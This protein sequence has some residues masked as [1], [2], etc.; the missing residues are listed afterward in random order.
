MA[1]TIYH[2][3]HCSKSRATLQLLRDNGVEPEICEYLKHP[4]AIPVL[5]DILVR[6]EMRAID[7]IRKQEPVFANKHVDPDKLSEQELLQFMVDNPIVIERPI[8]VRG[9]K[10]VIGRPPEKILELL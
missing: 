10:A 7:L 2:N 4:P 9:Q 6:L 3:P 5:K 8:V 1:I